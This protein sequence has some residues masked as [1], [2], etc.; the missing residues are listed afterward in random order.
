MAQFEVEIAELDAKGV[1]VGWHG[2]RRVLV[3]YT[4][5]GER[6]L[7]EPLA[8]TEKGI[9]GRGVRLIEASADRVAPRCFHFGQGRCGLCRWQHLDARVQPL[10]KQ[11]AF[12]E[13]LSSLGRLH[14]QRIDAA[15]RPILASPEAWGYNH[16]ITLQ[17][18]QTDEGA[19]LGFPN[20]DGG[21]AAPLLECHT[22]HPD[23]WSFYETLDLDPTGLRRV[24]LARGSDGALMAT[25]TLTTEEAPDIETDTAASINLILP[26]NEPM[27]LIG[28]SHLRYMLDGVSFRVTAGS[29][30]RPNIGALPGMIRAVIDLL[31]PRPTERI[32]DL[33]AGVGIFSAFIA[34]RASLVTLVESYPPAVTDADA[35]LSDFDN[36]DVIEGGVDAVL[37]ALEGQYAAA[38]VD[39]PGRFG[40]LTDATVSALVDRDVRRLIYVSEEPA[41]LARDCRKLGKAGFQLTAAQPVDLAPQ[42]ADFEVAARFER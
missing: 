26:D 32:L 2:R 13:M 41:T 21:I 12:A 31:D 29:F 38:V 14:D 4:I 7:V 27:N 8:E 42:T 18:T 5:P 33:Y 6:V 1:G 15:L 25:L 3:P 36:V 24:R 19:A 11:D 39:P 10:L 23:V 35:N 17:V 16:H 34:P 37:P 40:G 9:D 22:A 30:I 28:D 20:T